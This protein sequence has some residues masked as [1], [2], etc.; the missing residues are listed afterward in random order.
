MISSL[1]DR[2]N[3]G[4]LGGGAGQK[5]TKTMALFWFWP[6]RRAE[7]PHWIRCDRSQSSVHISH[8]FMHQIVATDPKVEICQNVKICKPSSTSPMTC[9]ASHTNNYRQGGGGACHQNS[10]YSIPGCW[11]KL[12]SPKVSILHPGVLGQIGVTKCL[13]IGAVHPRLIGQIAIYL[14]WRMVVG[15]HQNTKIS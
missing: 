4:K 6:N 9:V 15:A 12:V 14:I 10:R 5:W 8:G 3:G 2:S 1:I 7:P 11:D 13:D